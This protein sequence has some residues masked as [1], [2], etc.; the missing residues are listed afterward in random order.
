MQVRTAEDFGQ[1]IRT[2]RRAK[3]LT[4]TELTELVSVSIRLASDL[5]RGTRGVK[6]A[7]VLL[8]CV[9]YGLNI[10]VEPRE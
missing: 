1:A 3:G 7:T 8:I 9:R 6:V 2:Q 5:E 10:T 4:Q